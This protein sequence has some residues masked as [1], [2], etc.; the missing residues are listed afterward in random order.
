MKTTTPTKS[1]KQMVDEWQKDP[2]FKAAYDELDTEFTLL[3]EVL[4]AR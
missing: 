2:E 4:L 1:H 3:R